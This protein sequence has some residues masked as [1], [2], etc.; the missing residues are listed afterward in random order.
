MLIFSFFTLHTDGEAGFMHGFAAF[1]IAFSLVFGGD[2]IRAV[3]RKLSG[4][5][6]TESGKQSDNNVRK[7]VYA[8]AV[9][10][11][12]LIV[13]IAVVGLNGSFWLIYWLIAVLFTPPMWWGIEKLSRRA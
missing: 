1:Y 3:D 8:S 12:I 2:I 5:S 4:K 7:S 10:A 13:S 6:K 9:T 11:A